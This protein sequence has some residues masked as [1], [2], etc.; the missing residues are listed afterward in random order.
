MPALAIFSTD[1]RRRAGAGR[2]IW[3]LR[4]ALLRK[5]L[6]AT[7]MRRGDSAFGTKKVIAACLAEHTEFSLA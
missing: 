1:C 7:I 6:P 3:Y 4:R 5:G 2:P